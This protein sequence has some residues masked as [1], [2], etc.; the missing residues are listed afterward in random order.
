M[1]KHLI[2]CWWSTALP[3]KLSP[4]H[5]GFHTSNNRVGFL[6]N[7]CFKQLGIQLAVGFLTRLQDLTTKLCKCQ[8]QLYLLEFKFKC[9]ACRCQRLA[10]G[11][12]IEDT[13]SKSKKEHNSV[14]MHFELS[15]LIVRIALWIVN[16]YSAF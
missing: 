10:V 12:L 14:K 2:T 13:K 6:F 5:I 16:I 9:T 11:Y 1:I 4:V 8:A 7:V 3:I 15:P